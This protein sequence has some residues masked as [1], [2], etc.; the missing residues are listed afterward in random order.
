[1]D[2]NEFLQNPRES[3]NIELKSW[4]DPN[5]PEGKSKII[6]TAIAL[7]NFNGGYLGIGISDKGIPLV[8]ET[9]N[10][11]DEIFHQDSIQALITK[12]SS[13]P[14]EITIEFGE[15]QGKKFPFIVVPSGVRT[16]VAAKARLQDLS[17]PPRDLVKQD[18]VYVRTLAANNTP[19]TASACFS[20]WP[21][22]MNVCFDNREADIGRF[23]RRHLAGLD[24]PELFTQFG[25]IDNTPKLPAVEKFLNDC[26]LRFEKSPRADNAIEL[27][28]GFFEVAFFIVSQ[29]ERKDLKAD[30]NFLSSIMYANPS[31]SGWPLWLD[32]RG[33]ENP[34]ARPKTSSGGWEALIEDY[35]GNFILP[36]LDFWRIEPP[37]RFY[38]IRQ[39]IDDLIATKNG[40]KQNQNL[41]MDLAIKLVAEAI[42]VAIFFA[43]SMGYPAESTTLDFVFRWRGLQNRQLTNY[44]FKRYISPGRFSGDDEIVSHISVPLD[45]SLSSVP[46]IIPDAIERL[47]LA[48]SG[49]KFSTQVIEEIAAEGLKSRY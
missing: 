23:V 46:S 20:D 42:S 14:F 39:L 21:Q 24:L 26:Y 7:R 28:K 15:F 49:V 31:Y 2:L 19:S 18:T 29:D 33:F 48:F 3:L 32:S 25:I 41:A 4:I 22:I 10:N 17:K 6:K 27:G 13:E 47:F 38:H 1:M 9:P 11:L 40:T 34:R 12:Y 45:I 30:E 37:G 44:D 36:H 5:T 35:V 8:D 43:K 16:P